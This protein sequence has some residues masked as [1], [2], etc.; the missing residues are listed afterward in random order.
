MKKMLSALLC[1]LLIGLCAFAES[2]ALPTPSPS[3]APQE[4]S[5]AGSMDLTL[6]GETLRLDFAPDPKYSIC[7][8]GYI[9]ASFYAETADGLLYELYLT[10]P[11]AVKSGEEV[12]PDS[13]ISN[14]DI[15]SGLMLFVSDDAGMDICS[16][17][18]QALTGAYPEGSSYAIRFTHAVAN[19]SVYT[20]EGSLE[21]SLV[22]VDEYF[23]AT[24]TINTCSA[25][26]RFAM[27]TSAAQSDE[28][29][30]APESSET[31]APSQPGTS[32]VPDS[33]PG[34]EPTP[35]PK[36]DSLPTPPPHL[37]KPSNA[38]KI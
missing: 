6:N 23:Y 15:G 19:D 20:F 4:Q 30:V 17:A 38:R 14:G 36:K 24:S 35:A 7:K 3:A 22:E 5:D 11:Q 10:F 29:S 27:D 28:D 13:C 12:T 8:D 16:A 33:T 2:S 25:T 32:E 26:F 31:P 18:T 21:A 37:N 34:S 9:Q 1:A